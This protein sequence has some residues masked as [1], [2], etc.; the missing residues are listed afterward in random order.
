MPET[1]NDAMEEMAGQDDEISNEPI[2]PAV[3]P[4][5]PI[6]EPEK[7]SGEP[8][9]PKEEVAD[10]LLPPDDLKAIF[11]AFA[12]EEPIEEP[13]KPSYEP[14]PARQHQPPARETAPQLSD[15]PQEVLD[16]SPDQFMPQGQEFDPADAFIPG[17]P[18]NRAF[19]VAQLEQ[20]R[21]LNAFE[22]E[23]ER[24]EQIARQGAA[25][26]EK[27]NARMEREKWPPALRQKFWN[28]MTNNPLDLDMM[29]DSFLLSERRTLRKAQ[30]TRVVGGNGGE[31]PPVSK[32]S[33]QIEKPSTPDAIE[34]EVEELFGKKRE[35]GI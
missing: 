21:R 3:E 8:E 27:L 18:S 35:L 4:Q 14:H 16:I 26:I 15:I 23:R 22:K 6:K 31:P 9:K 29:A 20:N 32:A 17:T 28:R 10:T 33:R 11:E 12:P 25:A 24:Q 30:A 5:E 1:A 7:P 2:E 13:P 19:K 34:K